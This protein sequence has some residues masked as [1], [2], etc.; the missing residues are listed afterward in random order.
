MGL[1]RDEIGQEAASRRAKRLRVD[2]VM[3]DLSDEDKKD[4]LD[5]IRDPRI[6]PNVIMRALNKRGIQISE[7]AIRHAR[8]HY[9]TV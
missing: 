9:G 5:A 2:E 8:Q 6:V 7:N 4:L 1:L 3:D